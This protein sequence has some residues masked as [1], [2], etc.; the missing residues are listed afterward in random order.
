MRKINKKLFTMILTLILTLIAFVTSLYAWFVDNDSTNASIIGSSSNNGMTLTSKI[1]SLTNNGND[2]II[3]NEISQMNKY[4][5]GDS[6][7]TAVLLEMK[8]E[9]EKNTSC[10]AYIK[11]D[12]GMP[13]S[14]SDFPKIGNETDSIYQTEISNTIHLYK[15]IK[16]GTNISINGNELSF[17][18]SAVNPYTKDTSIEL[19]TGINESQ[20]LYFLIDYSD[21]NIDIIYSKLITFTQANINSEMIFKEDLYL[22]LVKA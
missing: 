4:N 20:T 13:N 18:N 21:K 8:I 15:V 16:N 6:A 5:N 1:Y 2:Y 3:G 12:K 14:S 11:T 7:C 19:S 17:I 22:E 9:L 10:S